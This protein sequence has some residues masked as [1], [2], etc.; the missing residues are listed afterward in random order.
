LVEILNEKVTNPA[1]VYCKLSITA[2]PN[3]AAA[4]AAAKKTFPSKAWERAA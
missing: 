1:A 3:V 4:G 2:S